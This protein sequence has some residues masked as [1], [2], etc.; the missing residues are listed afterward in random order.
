MEICLLH[1]HFVHLYVYGFKM[2]PCWKRF[3]GGVV[4]KK[5]SEKTSGTSAMAKA[6]TLHGNSDASFDTGGALMPSAASQVL[7]VF[8][9]II[10]PAGHHVSPYDYLNRHVIL[11][12]NVVQFGSTLWLFKIAPDTA[13]IY[14]WFMRIYLFKMVIFRWQTLSN[15]WVRRWSTCVISNSNRRLGRSKH[16]HNQ[17]LVSHDCAVALR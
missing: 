2:C 7:V 10:S 9:F 17:S 5:R 8:N 12:L 6:H 1:Q 13:P 11:K 15:K 3:S 4:S 14:R 16:W